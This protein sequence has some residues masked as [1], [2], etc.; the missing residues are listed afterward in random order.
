MNLKRAGALLGK[1]LLHGPRS[2]IFVM[3]IVMPLAVSLLVNLLLGTFFSEK[4]SLGITGDTG[5]GFATELESMEALDVDR[6]RDDTALQ[7]AVERG[8][9]IW[10]L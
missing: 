10:G 1:E 8:R 6:Y 7:R 3:A 9:R 2:Y 5:S 4:P